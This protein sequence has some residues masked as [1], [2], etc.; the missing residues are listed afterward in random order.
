MKQPHD[1]ELL[2]QH[3][4]SLE[5]VSRDEWDSGFKGNSGMRHD[6]LHAVEASRINDL[7]HIYLTF[8]NPASGEP[9][10][11][12]NLYKVEM[13]FAT[14]DKKLPR[15]ARAAIKEWYPHF[16][17]FQL[18]E[19]GLFTMVGEGLELQSPE[20]TQAILERLVSEMESIGH[21]Q[22]I[23]FFLIRDIPTGSYEPFRQALL[24]RG[25]R[26]LLG[27]ANAA[28]DIRWSSLEEYL[29]SL[30]AKT[31]YKLKTS[32][33]FDKRYQVECEVISDYAELA[34]VL[35]RL[36]K[37]VNQ[38]ASDY[39]REQLDE[40]FFTECARHLKGR[41]E[42]ILF[43]HRGEPIAFMFN[44]IGDD[45][46]I[47]LDWGVDYDF[48]HYRTANLYRAA[49]V[50][51]LEAAIRHGKKRIE[52]GITNY[53]P[54]LLLG[55]QVSPLVYFIRHKE[56]PEYTQTLAGLMTT[57]IE[58]P[59][60]PGE[61]GAELT[62][63]AARVR[64]DQCERDDHDIFQKVEQHHKF[65]SLKLAGI[66]GLYPE[67]TTAQRSSIQLDGQPGVVLLGTNSYLGLATHPAVVE[68]AKRAIDQYGTGCS[69]SPL[70][71]GTLDIHKLLESELAHF[72][73]KEAV[74]LCSTGFQANLTAISALAGPD[75]LLIMDARCHRSLFDGA[76]LSGAD[77]VLY[78]H[79][80]MEHLRRVL[81]R[82]VSRRKL[83]IT[84]S[85]FSMEGTIAPLD[86]LCDL[87]AEYGA[88]VY[89][90]ESHA[91]G[92]LGPGGRGVCELLGVLDRVDL[93]MGTF[94]K[95]LAA[96]GGFVAGK[97]EVIEYIKHN[98]SGHIFSASL[99]PPVIGTVRAALRVIQDEP[100]RRTALLR[101]AAYMAG[102]LRELGYQAEYHGS[103]IVPV[104]LGDYTLALAA[105]KRFM[106]AGVY[107]NP[108]GP[109][110]VPAERSG[111]RTSYMANHE[112]KD[113]EQALG[114]FA[115]FREQL[116]NRREALHPQ[117]EM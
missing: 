22:D 90:D 17:T 5:D 110:A 114:V 56:N 35:A 29:A 85:V 112:W 111:F 23:D 6:F 97:R 73:Q 20:H 10:A 21:E 50:L 77:L 14:M 113:L 116:T 87:A 96:L 42:V 1:L 19:C 60:L 84:D 106:Q 94:S 38:S 65:T 70:L 3:T 40:H 44:L 34:P 99:P 8:R 67:F 45:D 89:V 9:V 64:R 100:E 31:R 88:R 59:E 109:P 95:S 102:A 91:L 105:Y 11:R 117:W 69:G 43:K 13:D 16:M 79:A 53:T 30:D 52:L 92:V 7:E 61:A 48:E 12:A 46:Y 26:P 4:H 58:Q 107:V 81:A 27:F 2:V 62:Q 82:N 93:I 115:S 104:V 57:S 37:N 39:S 51:S 75:D 24:P 80:D 32:L 25:F 54:K 66:Y 78:R 47:M 55:A 71:N 18:L 74:V 36:W 76:K 108:V 103:P 72:V 41:S 15:E 28:L 98:G 68:A 49:S 33:Q 83:I 86:T 63:W 101:K